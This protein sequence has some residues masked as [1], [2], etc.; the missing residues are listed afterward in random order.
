[1]KA[2]RNNHPSRQGRSTRE[3]VRLFDLRTRSACGSTARRRNASRLSSPESATRTRVG[4][5]MVAL[6]CTFSAGIV[7][8]QAPGQAEFPGLGDPGALQTIEFERAGQPITF[9]DTWQRFSG[10]DGNWAEFVIDPR[11]GE[12]K[13]VRSDDGFHLNTNGA[14]IL[15]IDIAVAVRDALRDMGATI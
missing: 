14:E 9:V 1:M 2:Y 15:A 10:R 11:D 4:A 6:I 5:W 7:P 12:G 13:D 8:A 3:D